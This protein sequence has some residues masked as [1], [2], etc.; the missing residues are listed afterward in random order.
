MTRI[1]VVAAFAAVKIAAA[2]FDVGTFVPDTEP[3][4]PTFPDGVQR[5]SMHRKAQRSWEQ[6]D[7]RVRYIGARGLRA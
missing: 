4:G 7:F 5:L 1:N 6:D 2:S 3:A